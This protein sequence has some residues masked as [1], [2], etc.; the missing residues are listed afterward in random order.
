MFIYTDDGYFFKKTL[1]R[2]SSCGGVFEGADGEEDE[3]DCHECDEDVG[4]SCFGGGAVEG[5]LG[6]QADLGSP[7]AGLFVC[8]ARSVGSGLCEAFEGQGALERGFCAVLGAL[9]DPFHDV[10]VV[11]EVS[12]RALGGRTRLCAAYH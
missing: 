10:I 2:A 6:D 1:L 3:D 12:E 11:D 7:D 4:V 9:G 8:A 5:V